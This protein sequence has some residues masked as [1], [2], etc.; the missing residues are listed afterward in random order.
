MNIIFLS[1]QY[2][3][4][5]VNYTKRNAIVKIYM[6]GIILEGWGGLEKGPPFFLAQAGD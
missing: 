4:L 5:E 6:I 2:H 3:K 1:L